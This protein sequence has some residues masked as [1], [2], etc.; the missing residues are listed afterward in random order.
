MQECTVDSKTRDTNAGTLTFNQAHVKWYLSINAE[1]LPQAALDK[2]LPTF[3]NLSIEGEQIEFSK[4]FTDLHTVS[5][6]KILE[7]K[8]YGLSDAKNSI[9]IVS[10]IR[11]KNR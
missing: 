8:G 4:G 3:R 5:Y 7:G 1:N 2:G 6:Q 9:E 10:Q 11:N